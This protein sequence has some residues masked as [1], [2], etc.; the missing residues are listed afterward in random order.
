MRAQVIVLAG[1]S[2]AGKSRLAERLGLPVLRLDDFYKDGSDPSLPRI[3]DGPNAG[4]VDWDHPDSWLPEDAIK[5]IATLCETGTAEVPIYDIAHDGRT[6]WQSLDLG[7]AAHFVA[8]GIF[9]QDIVAE[10]RAAG[11]LAAAYCVTQSPT[12]TFWRRLTRDLREHRK[13]PFVLVKRGLALMRAQPRVVAD[14]VAK[15]CTAVY[16]KHGY[17]A[18]GRLLAGR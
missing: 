8:E 2:G 5:T 16:P 1:P 11:L 7:D 10:C 15:G 14:A 9:A 12:V 13:P 17:V 4:L 18:I 3:A 6:G